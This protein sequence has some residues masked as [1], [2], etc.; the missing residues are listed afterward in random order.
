VNWAR[1]ERQGACQLQP[2]GAGY[3]QHIKVRR[4][5]EA[6][7]C[8]LTLSALY[9]VARHSRL[10]WIAALRDVIVKGGERR[11][12]GFGRNDAAFHG[13][14]DGARQLHPT[15]VRHDRRFADFSAPRG[16]PGR[17]LLSALGRVDWNGLQSKPGQSSCHDLDEPIGEIAGV[18][19]P[20]RRCTA[21]ANELVGC[22]LRIFTGVE[23]FHDMCRSAMRQFL[24]WSLVSNQHLGLNPRDSR[25]HR[26]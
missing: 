24:Q 25:I 19:D 15:A 3:V 5:K 9:K 8:R 1:V 12:A 11:L 2:D 22:Q 23:C 18:R 16:I 26:R 4:P 13:K 14:S 7:C 20:G 21:R 17:G 6:V 10:A